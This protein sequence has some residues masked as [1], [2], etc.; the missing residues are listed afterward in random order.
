VQP[1]SWTDATPELA[2]ELIGYCRAR[3]SHIKCPKTV[4]FEAELPR[5]ATGKLYKR[6]LKDRYWS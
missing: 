5:H 2:A 6:L 1:R 4:D 3:L